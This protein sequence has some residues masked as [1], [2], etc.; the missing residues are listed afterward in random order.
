[1]STETELAIEARFGDAWIGMTMPAG[2]LDDVIEAWR[3]LLEE[4]KSEDARGDTRQ[5]VAE[6][7]MYERYGSPDELR[8]IAMALVWLA[9]TGDHGSDLIPRM[10]GGNVGIEYE[11]FRLGP[12]TFNFRLSLNEAPRTDLH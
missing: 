8:T 12:T 10:R 11:I 7:L 1:M 6:S 2:S 9:A 4:N 5:F 3:R